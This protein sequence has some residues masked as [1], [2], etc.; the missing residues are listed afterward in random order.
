[1]SADTIHIGALVIQ[2]LIFLAGLYATLVRTNTITKELSKKVDKMEKRLEDLTIVI[3]DQAVQAERLN[4]QSQRMTM[5]EQ[6][7]EDLRRGRGYVQN[8]GQQTV[9]GEYP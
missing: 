7:V 9:D 2:T 3:R 8:H 5:L 1:M 4:N 6:R